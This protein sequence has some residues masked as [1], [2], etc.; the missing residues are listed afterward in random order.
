MNFRE[1][2]RMFLD[3]FQARGH[4]IV[5]SS[6]LIPKDDPSLLFTNAGMVQFKSLFLGEEERS[7][8][9]AANFQKCI[10]AGGK[11]NDLENV[12]YTPRHHTFFEMLGNFS[13]GDY[14]KEDAITWAWDLL[15]EKYKLASNLLYVSVYKDDDEAYRIW[16]EKIG[17][18]TDRIVRLGDKEN[19]WTM[20]D[21]GPCGPCSEI[22]IDQGASLGCG[23][24]D[25]APGCDCDRYLEI[26][27]LV[28]TQFH[29]AKDGRLSPLSKQ[30][31]DTGMGLERLTAVVQKVAT[32]Y[33][34]DIFK[35]IISRIEELSSKGYGEDKRRDVAFRVISDH[36]RAVS[37]LIGDG[38]MPS[39]EGRGY[40]L[41]RIIRRA[42]RF[43]QFLGL[44]DFFLSPVC[45][46]VIEIMGRDYK[47][48]IQSKDLIEGILLNEEKRFA[49]TLHY[50]MKVL[51]EEIDNLKEKGSK[52]IPGKVAFKLYDTYGLSLDI[53][54]D[55]ARDENLSLDMEGFH[56]AMSGQ[57][58]LS[59]DSWKGSGQE[60][61]PEA[62][63][64]LVGRG[65]ATRFLGYE[66]LILKA[67]VVALLVKG[68]EVDS[69]ES[70]ADLEVVLEQTPFYGKAGGQVGDTGWIINGDMRFHVTDTLRP[71]NDLIIH[72]GRLKHG[73]ISVADEVEARVDHQKR[74]AIVANHTATH[75]LHAALREVLGE[76]VKQ[77]GSMVSSDRLRFDFSHFT[78]V[79][80]EKLAEVESVVN[81]H[82]RENLTV[83]TTETSREE[84]METGAMA[85]FEERYG[86][87]VRL[88]NIG[89]G[90]SMELCGG[91][92]A[93]HTGNIGL[94]RIISEV[95]VGANIRRIEAL[96]G[97]AALK[98]DQKQDQN[99]TL[100]ASLL[101]S[102]QDKVG[103]RIIQLLKE[104]KKKDREL[105]SLRSK[106]LSKESHTYL[107]EVREI[108]GVK[109]IARAVKV[110]SSKELRE[111]ADQVKDS[112][113]SGIILLG[114]KV[115][116]KVMLICIV[117]E[118]LVGRFR[119]GDII[120]Q[121]STIVG[122]KGGGRSDMAQGGGDKPENLNQAIEAIYGLVG[123]GVD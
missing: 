35:G 62:Y 85:I 20:G 69:V 5:G 65:F 102:A 28:F 52:V 6:S 15:T 44:K 98:Y 76:H 40:V 11:H 57:R 54:E 66:T 110:D 31:I 10:R 13:F 112:L 8:T 27:N 103:E 71:K 70:G 53:V 45:G 23:R 21:T 49:D 91:T 116:G 75:L 106:L 122:G 119:A 117:S 60:E 97:D 81:R 56:K 73:T 34:T 12:G 26:W 50:G 92:H 104:L 123:K 107:D 111:V 9:R 25:C 19:F 96:T 47:E 22:H 36:A 4:E 84:A 90:V 94:F 68:K 80:P 46:K 109:V 87:R 3:Y 67:K 93:E 108:E 105:K 118:D 48:L 82:I 121:L 100:A 72:K 58:T 88:V 120:K 59:Q 32:N 77:A 89:E 115:E 38:V 24:P 33:D 79:S 101:N 37:F 114:T 2:R 95:A 99:I 55:V 16:E 39:N 113:K 17:I 74:K 83:H 30:N 63:R 64:K 1:I 41:K 14:F 29:R 78:Q 18:P 86:E 43:G 51:N 7:Y 61:I 42:I